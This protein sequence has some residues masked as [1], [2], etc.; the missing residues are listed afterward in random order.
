MPRVPT[1]VVTDLDGTLL[2][3]ETYSFD[4]ARPALDRLR[5]ERIPLVL[6]TSK[7]RAEVE[8]LRTALANS[9]PFIVENGGGVYIPD[10]YFPF[11]IADAIQRE[12]AWLLRLGDSYADL[13][14]ALARASHASGVMVRGFSTMSDADVAAAT[15]LALPDARLARRREFDEPFEILDRGRE[16]DLV[17]AIEREGKRVTKGGRFHHIVGSNDKAVAVRRLVAL[18]ARHRG[19]VRTIGLGD[20]VN[21]AGFLSVVDEPI[22]VA[23]SRVE[24]LRTLLPRAPVTDLPGPA[25]WNGAVLARLNEGR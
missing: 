12:S 21:D 18:F 13:V 23:S 4:A 24:Q 17:T 9:H 1:V 11:P 2:D 16:R 20:A 8:P 25:G 5:D 22:L 3:H 10:G 6:C 14:A 15:G 7:T 19:A